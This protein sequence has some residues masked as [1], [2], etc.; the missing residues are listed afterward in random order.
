VLRLVA[1]PPAIARPITVG[2]SEDLQVGQKVFAIGNPFGLDQTLTTGIISGI[3]RSIR[4][5]TNH[6]ITGVIQTDAAINPGNSGGPLLDSSGRLIGVNTA[7]VSPSGAYAG[8]GF[9][10]PVDTIRQ[11]VPELIVRGVAARPG[12]GVELLDAREAAQLGLSGIGIRRVREG[13]AAERAGLR[14]LTQGRNGYYVDEIV[15]IDDVEVRTEENLFDVLDEKAPGETVVLRVRR[16]S[17]VSEI[18]VKLQLI[19]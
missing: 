16:G 14:S 10:V 17:R 3:G 9:A 8:I 19:D 18:P 13:S 12:L 11:V 2:T 4:S 1:E 7:I 15:G 6:K 5:L